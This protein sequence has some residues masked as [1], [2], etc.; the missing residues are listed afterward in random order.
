MKLFSKIL[1]LSSGVLMLGLGACK[2]SYLDRMPTDEVPMSDAFKTTTGCKAA[3]E[4]IHS[5]M[6]Q[7]LDHDEFGQK[8][9][10]LINDL[11]GDD[12]PVSGSGAGWFVGFAN[13]SDPRSGRGYIWN[14][15]YKFVLNCNE[16][17][18]NIDKAEGP[19]SEKDNIKGQVY[20]YL[21]F[22]YYNL[23]IYY[24]HTYMGNPAAPGVPIYHEP[25]QTANPRAS[26]Q[27]VYQE[28]TNDLRK[29]EVLLSPANGA[30][31]RTDKSEI[32]IDVVHGLHA[33]VALVM[34]DYALADS[35]A[36][37]ARQN[38]PYM[39]AKQLMDGF[40]DWGNPAW[41]W[42][43]YLNEEQNGIYASFLSQMDISLGGYAAYGQQKM[44]NKT[45]YN[46]MPH[47]SASAAGFDI[48]RDWWY[49]RDE[50]PSVKF[51][52][53]KFRAK[54]QGSFS[55]D[56]IYMRAAEMGFIQAEAKVF[57]NDIP[58]AQNELQQIMIIRNPKYDASQFTDPNALLI[59]I[60]HQRRIELWGEGFRFSDLQRC[61]A[62]SAATGTDGFGKLFY[63]GLHRENS[64]GEQ[65]VY[66]TYIT[67][68]DPYANT[69]LFRIPTSELNYNPNMVQ[70]P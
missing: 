39:S 4:G 45:L 43:S 28:I 47:D 6:Y 18:A 61:A 50:S 36:G 31:Q 8:S 3:L 59:E 48:R 40:N 16:I 63:Q 27:E 70:N 32:N 65:T 29:A 52:Q 7:V 23:S 15:Y 11:M 19:Q 22:A 57:E 13:Y 51:S 54:I 24:Q 66:G 25:T 30:P 5:L 41:I 20:F 26:L 12:M 1:L 2:K 9:I 58:G 10:D 35:M 14:Y 56:V 69:F 37:A 53:K 34:Q 67:I 46:L 55:S 60:W 21:A 44:I 38:Y 64:G 49:I 42:G 62:V 68:T 33:R 17:L